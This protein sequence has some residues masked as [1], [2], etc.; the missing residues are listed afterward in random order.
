MKNNTLIQ[1]SFPAPVLSEI[2][3]VATRFPSRTSAIIYLI[4]MGLEREGIKK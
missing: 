4:N 3:E 2:E 1:V